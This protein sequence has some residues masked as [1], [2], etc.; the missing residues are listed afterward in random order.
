VGEASLELEPGIEIAGKFRLER[1]IGRGGMGSVWA[2]EQLQLH[3]P[4]ALKFMDPDAL[5]PESRVRF[6]REARAAGALR[7]PHVVQVLDHG[8][9]YEIPFF[10]MELLEG[11]DLGERLRREGA[12]SIPAMAKIMLQTAKGLRRA[13]EAGIIHRDLK[14]G[15]LFLARFDD[16]EIVKVLDF[17]VAK[18]RGQDGSEIGGSMTQTGIVFGSPSYMSPEQ[19]RGARVLDHRTDLWSLAVIAFRAITG[20]KPFVGDS[21]ADLVIKLCI[22]PIPLPSGLDPSMP[23][24]VDAFFERAFARDPDQRFQT[25]V[26]MANEFAAVAGLPLEDGGRPD[27]SLAPPLVGAMPRPRPAPEV[28]SAS[29]AVPT[30]S[31]PV[32]VPLTEALPTLPRDQGSTTGGSLKGSTTGGVLLTTTG[33]PMRLASAPPPRP[34]TSPSKPEERKPQ[35]PVAARTLLSPVH[36]DGSEPTEVGPVAAGPV[37]GSAPPPPREPLPKPEG[38]QSMRGT[39]DEVTTAMGSGPHWIP[40]VPAPPNV[41]P[42]V[43]MPSTIDTSTGAN[44]FNQARAFAEPSPT[45]RP[46]VD[47]RA[48]EPRRAP[49]PVPLV[50]AIAGVASL[51]VLVLAGV[52]IAR[53]RAATPDATVAGLPTVTPSAQESAAPVAPTA[54]ASATTTA[55]TTAATAPTAEPSAS[56]RADPAEASAPTSAPSGHPSL[57]TSGTPSTKPSGSKP[58]S[59]KKKKP[60]FGY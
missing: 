52:A 47:R 12:I 3:M 29:P 16:D 30:T 2:A 56:A 11:E 13:H 32:F 1:V 34:S 46:H 38:P 19:A 17:G 59:T 7:S 48:P 41:P 21:I 43:P 58:N 10:V 33:A 14:P 51:I 15:N 23:A 18:L 8:L 40:A 57:S 44:P 20:Q 45:L 60:N 42:T 22:D 53:H 36:I 54:E 37:A 6:E 49:L 27:A 28:A 55:A 4:V 24:R 35:V 50:L 26:A 39:D 9:D 31:L 5:S 25:A